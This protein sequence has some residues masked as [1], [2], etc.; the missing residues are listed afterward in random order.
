LLADWYGKVFARVK[1]G[2]CF[3]KLVELC[4][5]VRQ[6]GVLSTVLFAVSVN[7]IITNHECS[8]YGCQVA[9]K[10]IAV[11]MYADD[12]IL[13]SVSCTDLRQM[14]KIF[15]EDTPWLFFRYAL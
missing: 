7:H 6:G 3:S 11:I 14:I 15:E 5:G 8:G 13:I 1:W 2:R 9:S 4:T 12:L 10:Y